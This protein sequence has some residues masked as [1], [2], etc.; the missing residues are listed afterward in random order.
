MDFLL[1][2]GLV[3]AD[4]DKLT[5]ISAHQLELRVKA[6]RDWL[7]GG[8][9]NDAR[10]IK[11]IHDDAG[12]SLVNVRA[13]DA[14]HRLKAAERRLEDLSLDFVGRPWVELN[15]ET[16]D[17]VPF[18]EQQLRSIINIVRTV[19]SSVYWVYDPVLL[20]SFRY[21]NDALREFDAHEKSPGYPLWKRLAV[22]KGFYEAF[23]KRRR[24]MTK[25]VDEVIADVA[26]RVP[27]LPTGPDAGQQ[28][29]PTQAL[30]LPL[31]LFRQELNF[32]ANHPQASIVAGGTSLGVTTV[33]FKIAS[34]RYLEA[35]DRMDVIEAEISAPGK[36]VASFL[37]L[38]KSWEGLR[39]EL[40]K[41]R[42]NLA[43]IEAFFGDAPASVLREID[44]AGLRRLTADLR[45]A[46]EE[47]GIRDGT[48]SRE[49]AG[50]PALQLVDGLKDDLERL[51]DMPR[52]LRDRLE[53]V[54]QQIVQSLGEQYQRKY[55]AR[56]SALTRIRTAQG[57]DLPIWPDKK[58]STYGA[59]MS[60]FDG[61]V[62]QIETEGEAFFKDC[63][64]TTFAVFVALC[65]LALKE[66]QIDWNASEYKRH[67]PV[68]MEK[69]LLEL[70]LV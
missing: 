40:R 15:K 10:V 19:R 70:R 5:R 58:G 8:F 21:S 63:G 12:D 2:L 30:T 16:A 51:R 37:E 53:E 44:L 1:H 55:G 34:A 46:V 4:G 26:R 20:G 61:V 24:E 28:A 7:D 67:V 43:A 17:G 27:V 68:L 3:E 23:D 65:E 9:E 41:L 32:N 11:S 18:Y 52:Q 48:D 29:F 38:L 57:K 25:R 60:L 59:T 54:E 13:K 47:G 39:E 49:V 69:G 66:R 31:G 42:E 14:R 35:L 36:L 64:E 33:G 56:L 45:Q 6:A 50:L 22:L 62:R